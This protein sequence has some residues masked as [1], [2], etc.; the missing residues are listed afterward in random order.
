V[1]HFDHRYVEHYRPPNKGDYAAAWRRGKTYLFYDPLFTKDAVNARMVDARKSC[2]H[3]LMKGVGHNTIDALAST[4]RFR[5]LI[6]LP[7]SHSRKIPAKLNRWKRSTVAYRAWVAQQLLKTDR[8]RRTQI[9]L[10][11][12]E[13][14]LKEEPGNQFAQKILTLALTKELSE[15]QKIAL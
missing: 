2:T 14:C 15:K 3:I 6:D 5:D 7:E 13:S 8:D 9:A 1:G 4:H 12:L 11:L 10:Q